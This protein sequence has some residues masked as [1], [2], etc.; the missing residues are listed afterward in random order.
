MNSGSKVLIIGG[1][2]TGEFG[3]YLYHGHDSGYYV[4]F[5]LLDDNIIVKPWDY[6]IICKESLIEEREKRLKQITEIDQ[7]LNKWETKLNEK[8]ET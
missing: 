3:T 4:P 1:Y 5:V 6:Q 2:H 8:I 7:Q